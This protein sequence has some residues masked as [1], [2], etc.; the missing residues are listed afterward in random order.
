[1]AAFSMDFEEFFIGGTATTLNSA[2]MQGGMRSMS[3]SWFI[4]DP[5][6]LR[7]KGCGETIA[8]F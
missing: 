6:S 5:P 3:F 4:R 7:C 2:G 1:M 8:I